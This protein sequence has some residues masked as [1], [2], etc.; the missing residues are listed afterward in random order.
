MVLGIVYLI[1][2]IESRTMTGF[3]MPILIIFLPI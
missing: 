1:F 3:F 2:V